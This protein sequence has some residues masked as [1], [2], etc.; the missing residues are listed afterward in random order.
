MLT[1]PSPLH[2]LVV[3]MPIALTIL[4]PVFAIGALWA[5]RRGAHIQR[6]WGIAA[7]MLTLL[8]ASGWV[9]LQTG[10]GE[11]EKVEKVVSESAIEQHEESAEAF[12]VA[13]G[14]VLLLAGAGLVRG[15]V[16]SVAR[17]VATAGTFALI[18]AG[19][20]VGHSGGTLVYR[21]GAGRAYTSSA[22][23]AAAEGGTTTE[24]GGEVDRNLNPDHDDR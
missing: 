6:A 16:G 21:E 7:A 19:Y 17:A 24:R 18:G 14:V 11:E 8:L 1:L 22:S 2:P 13:T 3:H 9:A 15:R 4:V 10:Q 20:N 12:L 5:I 23:S